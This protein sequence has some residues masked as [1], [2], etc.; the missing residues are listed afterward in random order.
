MKSGTFTL[1]SPTQ[2]HEAWQRVAKLRT[3]SYIYSKKHAKW[4]HEHAKSN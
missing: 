4:F 1:V 2:Q 3:L